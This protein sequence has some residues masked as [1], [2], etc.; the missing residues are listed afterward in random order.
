MAYLDIEATRIRKERKDAYEELKKWLAQ[1]ASH[2]KN[3][4]NT[5][6]MGIHE[7]NTRILERAL[8]YII[9]QEND[10]AIIKEHLNE[11]QRFFSQLQNFLPRRPSIHDIIS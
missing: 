7:L 4:K 8:E 10:M 6:S 2:K 1:E 5:A 3:E 11:Y 9:E